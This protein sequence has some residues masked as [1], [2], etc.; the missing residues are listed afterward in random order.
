MPC[1][2]HRRT[3]NGGKPD[4]KLLG[5]RQRVIDRR[6]AGVRLLHHRRGLLVL[7]N[8]GGRHWNGNV[9]RRRL[10]WLRVAV[11]GALGRVP[12]GLHAVGRR[13]RVRSWGGR[14]RGGLPRRRRLPRDAPNTT[15][16]HPQVEGIALAAEEEGIL[17]L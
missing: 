7:R 13:H 17:R 8:D 5:K 11:L 10:H 9:H 12:L 2:A 3:E 6:L 14:G 1:D 16:Q 15:V 4:S